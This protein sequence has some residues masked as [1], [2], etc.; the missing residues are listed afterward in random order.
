M[1]QEYIFVNCINVISFSFD[2]YCP[3]LNPPIELDGKQHF[4]LCNHF[5]KSIG[6]LL[7]RPK[8]DFI[9]TRYS[10]KHYGSIRISFL[11]LNNSKSIIG[12][13]ICFC[14]NHCDWNEAKIS[15]YKVI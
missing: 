3:E 7:D 6:G 2:A 8:N 15:I 12:F 4:D 10:V 5:N 13:V 14:W 9:K 1:E 11:C